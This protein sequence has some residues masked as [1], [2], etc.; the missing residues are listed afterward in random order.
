MV[1]EHETRGVDN[2]FLMQIEGV[3]VFDITLLGV[4]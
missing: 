4:M 3:N 1:F 2:S